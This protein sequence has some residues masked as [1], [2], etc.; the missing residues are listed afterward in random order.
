MKG[1]LPTIEKL[2]EI[3]EHARRKA[4]KEMDEANRHQRMAWDWIRIMERAEKMK[5][6]IMMLEN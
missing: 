1:R 4:E 3:F 5:K 6:Q 2:D